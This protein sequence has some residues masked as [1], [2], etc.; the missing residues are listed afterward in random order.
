MKK[1]IL[2]ICLLVTQLISLSA[3]EDSA[4]KAERMRYA[5]VLRD[6]NMVHYQRQQALDRESIIKSADYIFEGTASTREIYTLVGGDGK[7]HLM[8]STIVSVTKIFRGNLK[9]GTVEILHELIPEQGWINEKRE[10][11][12]IPYPLT[13]GIYLCIINNEFPFNLSNSIHPVDNKTILVSRSNINLIIAREWLDKQFESK[14][15]IYKYIRTWPNIKMP[16]IAAEDTMIKVS[17]HKSFSSTMTKAHAD[18]VNRHLELKKKA[19]T[20]NNAKSVISDKSVIIDKSMHLTKTKSALDD[21]YLHI[22]Y[23]GDDYTENTISIKND[24]SISLDYDDNV[25]EVISDSWN[26]SN[27]TIATINESGVVK[28]LAIGSTTITL[29][30]NYT[31]IDQIWEPCFTTD[32][33][34]NC[35]GAYVDE[36]EY[37]TLTA[38]CTIEVTASEPPAL[39]SIDLE[40]VDQEKFPVTV[41]SDDTKHMVLYVGDLPDFNI[42][43]EP[44]G[45]IYTNAIYSVDNTSV[46]SITPNES[47]PLQ[48]T[49]TAIAPGTA[50]ITVAVNGT[51][52]TDDISIRVCPFI[53]EVTSENIDDL[54]AGDGQIITIS[55]KGSGSSN[56]YV[57]FTSA[58][59]GGIQHNIADYDTYD[60]Q[61]CSGC[62]WKDDQIIMYLPGKINNGKDADDNQILT[63]IGSGKINMIEILD[64]GSGGYYSNDESLVINHNYLQL[65]SRDGTLKY[66]V[67]IKNNQ[68]TDSGANGVAFVLDLTNIPNAADKDNATNAIK[69]A[70]AEWSCNLGINISIDQPLASM[71]NTI[72]FGTPTTANAGMETN[73]G[74]TGTCTPIGTDAYWLGSRNII[75]NTN[76]TWDYSL[77]ESGNECN[78][79]HTILHEIGHVL[80][81]GHI[82]DQSEFIIWLNP[83][84]I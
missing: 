63:T 42:V 35:I 31:Y 44:D 13:H 38:S 68:I 41:N 84:Y 62:S 47:N 52:F 71:P 72:S 56:G 58:D 50:K 9:L 12:K 49:I 24:E 74:T 81:L 37:G 67:K 51:D 6:S 32:D 30:V 14:A 39:E 64:D 75:I 65:V 59:D 76:I 48:A 66:N 60:Y 27:T 23:N 79:Y 46:L 17:G 69:R 70:M 40:P 53:S 34:D 55:G 10:I 78:F 19:I 21:Y 73:W 4:E 33:D 5:K 25:A 2:V 16:V 11:V 29:T 28:A 77:P 15:Q 80:Q 3:Q 61:N 83:M 26:S 22:T 8:S 36:T 18:S 57:T 43:L 20:N 1:N 45:S 82:N 7:K 54:S